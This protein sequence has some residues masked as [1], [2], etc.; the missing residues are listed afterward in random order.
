MFCSHL[1]IIKIN[2]NEPTGLDVEKETA[3]IR[4]MFARM[5]EDIV[6]R[7]ILQAPKDPKEVAR[8]KLKMK[9]QSEFDERLKMSKGF[10]D[11]WN[12][13]RDFYF[14]LPS[15]TPKQAS[16]LT[17]IESAIKFCRENEMDLNMMIACLHRSY[18]KRTIKPSFFNLYDEKALDTYDSFYNTVLAD[19]D[20]EE[21]QEVSSRGFND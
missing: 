16:Q 3:K 10:I 12:K 15:Y 4:R 13:W 19:L 9:K 18:K 11:L 14:G 5:S 20:R 1:S 17:A 2:R 7:N 6:V 8:L 21:A